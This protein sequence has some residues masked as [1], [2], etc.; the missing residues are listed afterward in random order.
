MALSYVGSME[1]NISSY[2][3]AGPRFAFLLMAIFGVVGLFLVTVGVYSLLAYTTSRKTREIGIRLALGA[4]VADVVALI[5]AKGLRLVVAGIALGLGGV[6]LMG[7]L[8][9]AQLWHVSAS[10]P[11]TLAGVAVLMLGTGVLACWIPAARA[12]RVDPLV[13]IRYE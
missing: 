10:D 12:S 2:S 7:R 6:L 8:I 5:L 1:G 3:Y 11:A 4:Q 13:A 9:T